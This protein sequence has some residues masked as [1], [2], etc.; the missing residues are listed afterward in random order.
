MLASKNH[1]VSN[2]IKHMISPR[3]QEGPF[4]WESKEAWVLGRVALTLSDTA[5]TC[6]H[7][8]DLKQCMK[9]ETQVLTRPVN[10]AC[11]VCIT[12]S[13]LF[14]WEVRLQMKTERSLLETNNRCSLGDVLFLLDVSL[15][16]FMKTSYQWVKAT[17]SFLASFHVLTCILQFLLFTRLYLSKAIKHALCRKLL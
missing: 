9:A 7:N 12:H 15:L 10:Q 14:P 8:G 6:L 3:E 5:Q 13:D 17:W 2:L 4:E 11:F 16:F 1:L